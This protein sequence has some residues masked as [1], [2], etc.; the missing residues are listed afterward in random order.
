MIY[1][2]LV[3]SKVFALLGVATYLVHN[4]GSRLVGACYGSLSVEET[5]LVGERP[6]LCSHIDG[7]LEELEC[8]GVLTISFRE[9]MCASKR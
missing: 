7:G 8:I 6:G 3:T 5:P 4:I 9:C 1:V 2:V